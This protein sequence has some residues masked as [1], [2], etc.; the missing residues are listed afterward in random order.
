MSRSKRLYILLGVLLAVCIMTFAVSRYEVKKEEIR[1]SG[2]VILTIEPDSVTALSWENGSSNLAFHKD[3]T[4]LYDGDAAFPVDEDK[5]NERLALFENLSAAFTIENVEDYGQYGLDDPACTVHITTADASYDISLGDYSKMDSQRYISIG[6]G[7]VY[8][9]ADDP[10]DMFGTELKAMIRNDVTPDVDKA[11][12]ISFS[13]AENYTAVYDGSGNNS[14]CADDVYFTDGKPLDT[15]RVNSYLRA[16]SSL[17][18]SDYATYAVNEDKLSFYGLDEPELTVTLGYTGEDSNGKETP[19]V[20]TLSVGRNK[21]ELAAAESSK[22]G[23][24]SSVQAYARVGDSGIIYEISYDSF[25]KLIAASYDDLRHGE[26]FTAS[27]DDVNRVDISLEGRSY[28]FALQD[29]EEN[30]KLFTESEKAWFCNGVKIDTDEFQSALEALSADSFTDETPAQKVEISL[31]LH[32]SNESFP[33]VSIVL[34]RY[35]GSSC[36]AVVDGTPTAL[37]P[38]AQAVELIEAVNSIVLEPVES[39]ITDGEE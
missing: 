11:D 6:D 3:G 29:D 1:E 13:G 14:S 39:E 34:Y 12:T 8:L 16:I 33:T 20:F 23:D 7:R 25:E 4:W 32:L 30:K 37:V 21:K 36:L 15:A 18:L 5:I 10:L 31:T 9:A 38:R 17:S 35:N 24:V 27:F 19:A 28:S 2:E 22:E 26:I